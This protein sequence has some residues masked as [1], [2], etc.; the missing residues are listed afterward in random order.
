MTVRLDHTI[1][2]ARDK[3]ESATFL[4]EILGLPAPAP[5]AHFL[6]VQI[7]NGLSLDFDNADGEIRPQHYA[8]RVSDEEFD[9]IF[10]RI[11]GRE[12]RYWADPRRSRPGEIAE[13]SPGRA[14]YFEDPSGHFLE[15]L[16]RPNE[17]QDVA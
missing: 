1:I 15:V 11:Q 4:A 10:G 13:R 5:A 7:G 16:T 17:M 8:F 14:F 2:A 9:A 12:L 3:H 6:V